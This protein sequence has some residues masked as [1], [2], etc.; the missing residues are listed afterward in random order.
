MGFTGTRATT[1]VKR[2]EK[3]FPEVSGVEARGNDQVFLGDVAEGGTING[4]DACNYYGYESDPKE[5]IWVMGVHHE[6]RRV[7][8]EAGFFVECNDPGT[9]YAYRD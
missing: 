7:C 4:V 3:A 1:L 2:I 6:L 5:R 9:Y 8:K